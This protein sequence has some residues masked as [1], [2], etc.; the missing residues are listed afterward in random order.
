MKDHLFNIKICALFLILAA[1]K[2]LK[3]SVLV[4]FKPKKNYNNPSI[5]YICLFYWLD[6]FYLFQTLS[7]FVI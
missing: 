7:I 6:F 4:N 3:L 2:R 1:V 5:F